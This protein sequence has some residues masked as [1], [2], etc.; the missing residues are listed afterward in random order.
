[1]NNQQN[2]PEVHPYDD[3]MDDFDEA[4]DDHFLEEEYA[5]TYSLRNVPNQWQL[6]NSAEYDYAHAQEILRVPDCIILVELH[7]RNDEIK[8]EFLDPR[9]TFLVSGWMRNMVEEIDYEYD[10]KNITSILFDMLEC[11]MWKYKIEEGRHF[12]R[13]KMHSVE[14]QDLI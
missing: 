12:D 7:P 6:R 5:Y 10:V 4:F 1:M 3:E 2:A 8:V 9:I 14:W 11:F 13:K